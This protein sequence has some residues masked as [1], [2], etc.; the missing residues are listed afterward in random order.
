M[1]YSYDVITSH[2]EMTSF[3]VAKYCMDRCVV[4]GLSFEKSFQIIKEHYG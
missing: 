1:N 4:Y 3:I 2:K